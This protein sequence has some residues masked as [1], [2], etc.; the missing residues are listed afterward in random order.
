MK[1][2]FIKFKNADKTLLIV[3]A[4]LLLFGLIMLSSASVAVGL[5][6]FGDSGFYIKR[7]LVALLIGLAGF[8][9]AYKTD[10]HRWHKLAFPLLALT[11]VLLV[12]V[13]IP[14]IGAA[15]YGAQR[16][17]NL[18][19][20]TFQ[21]SELAKLTLVLYLA[22][23]IGERGQALVRDFKTGLLPLLFLMGILFLLIILQPDL[24]TLLIICAIALVLYFVG[25]ANLKHLAGL[26]GSGLILVALVIKLEPYRLAR[27]TTFFNP[28]ADPQ[29][30]GYHITQALLAIGSG[31]IFG[32][33]LGH[34]RQKFLY[35]PEVTGD[36]IFAVIAEELGFIG[37][38][39]LVVLFLLFLWRGLRI[40]RRAP[41]TYGKLLATG[42]TAWIVI[43]AFVNIGAMVGVLPLTGLPLPLI[44]YG[45]S[46]LMIMLFGIGILLNISKQSRL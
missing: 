28:G 6:R 38:I 13:L 33:G 7:Q 15:G 46:A 36:S 30:A 43:Q 41:D 35:L 39:L 19:V 11:L 5:N 10:Y 42:L 1:I 29:G 8:Y 18:Y 17:L 20:T 31:G 26:I 12:L 40:A 37:S 44:S 32:L 3:T 34:S 9:Y 2:H 23:W 16:W 4:I 22:G 21:P 24:G 27:L 14:G 25:G 45:G